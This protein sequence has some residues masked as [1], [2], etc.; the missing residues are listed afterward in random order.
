[1]KSN[2]LQG[3]EFE[4]PIGFSRPYPS[5]QRGWLANP[6]FIGSNP[7]GRLRDVWKSGFS[8]PVWSGAS[9]GSNPAVAMMR[10]LKNIP[11]KI[12]N[13]LQQCSECGAEPEVLAWFSWRGSRTS[14]GIESG[15]IPVCKSCLFDAIDK[16]VKFDT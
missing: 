4:S 7:I 13:E 5:G 15:Q 3:Q 12:W 8:I 9:A 1:M 14:L 2:D 11:D 6:L 10:V 16:M